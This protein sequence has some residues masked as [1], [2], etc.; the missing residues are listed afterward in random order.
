MK[1]DV[2]L[3]AAGY[4]TRLYPLTKNFPKPLLEVA[5]KPV[6][7]NI[8]EKLENLEDI[9]KIY[10]VTN[11][12]YFNHFAEWRKNLKTSLKIEILND[13]TLSEED[14]LGAIG[15]IYF[16]IKEKS[17]KNPVLMIGGDNLFDF[18]LNDVISY[19]KEK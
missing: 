16:A 15:D 12:R 1:I 5:G 3:L 14:K 13:E 8:V 7:T 19:F 10:L 17:I 18:Q 2:I 4:S 6:I 9:N 11:N